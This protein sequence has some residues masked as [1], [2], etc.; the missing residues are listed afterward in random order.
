MTGLPERYAGNKEDLA[1]TRS[2]LLAN[3]VAGRRQRLQERE[4][5]RPQPKAPPQ[6]VRVP[7]DR[8][9]FTKE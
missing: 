4:R 8:S 9:I 3:T 5:T 6:G 7:P 2:A 1:R